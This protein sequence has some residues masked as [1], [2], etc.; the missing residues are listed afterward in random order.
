FSELTCANSKSLSRGDASQAGNGEFAPYQKYYQPSWNDLYLN[1]C[2][3]GGRHEEFIRD[4]IEQR[5]DR[6][7]LFPAPCEVS[8]EQIGGCGKPEN[9][10]RNQIVADDSTIPVKDDSLLHQDRDK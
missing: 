3:Q 1:E 6:C 9:Q 10:Q 8:I 5:T 7:N 2:N 4:W